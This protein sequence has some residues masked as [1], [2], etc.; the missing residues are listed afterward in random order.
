MLAHDLDGLIVSN[1]TLAREGLADAETGNAVTAIFVYE[2]TLT[3]NIGVEL[4]LGIPPTIEADATGTI[5]EVL[6]E[7][8]SPVEFGQPLFVIE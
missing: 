3:P 7:N 8:G 4:V 2:R 6:V 1:T 5:R